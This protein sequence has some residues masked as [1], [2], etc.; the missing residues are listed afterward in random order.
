[1]SAVTPP[2]TLDPVEARE[3]RKR[4]PEVEEHIR[5]T[6]AEEVAPYISLSTG[7]CDYKNQPDCSCGGA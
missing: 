5:A 2:R 1:M 6:L 3:I 4:L 7:P